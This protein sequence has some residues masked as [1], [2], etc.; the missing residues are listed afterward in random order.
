MAYVIQ[1]ATLKPHTTHVRTH[2]APVTIQINAVSTL[3]Q[4]FATKV[5]QIY[6]VHGCVTVC[7]K[8]LQSVCSVHMY[9]HVMIM[10]TS[11]C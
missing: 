7:V 8:W 6:C 2:Q 1:Y 10:W 9:N 4:I 11:F 5:L 3:A